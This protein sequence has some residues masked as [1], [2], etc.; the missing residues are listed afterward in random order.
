MTNPKVSYKPD[1]P[2]IRMQG[3]AKAVRPLC[4]MTQAL[5]C[6]Q[7][8]GKLGGE[9]RKATGGKVQLRFDDFC[10][11]EGLPMQ[12]MVGWA[13]DLHSSQRNFIREDCVPKTISG[14]TLSPYQL[15][16]ITSTPTSGGVHALGCGLGK[17]ITAVAA[18][19]G[20][21]DDGSA[22]ATRCWIVCPLNAVPAWE[23]VRADLEDVF[24]EVNIL[25]MDSAHKYQ[26][27]DRHAGGCIIYDEVHLLGSDTARR[28][29]A[30]HML[31]PAFQFGLCLTGTLLHGGIEKTMSI[32]DLAIPGAAMFSDRWAMGRHFNCLVRKQLG[33]RT[34][35]ELAKPVDRNREGFF[36]Y[37]DTV[38]QILNQDNAQVVN[39]IG[40]IQQTVHVIPMG[41]PYPDIHQQAADLAIQYYEDEGKY[42][43]ASW[44]RM[45]LLA[46]R[47]SVAGKISWLLEE[48]AG[49]EVQVVVFDYF[50]ENLNAIA[51]A[52]DKEKVSYVRVDGSVTG[53]DRAA[54]EEKFQRDH[55][56]V[57]LGQTHAASVS[58]NLQ[59]AF[60][61]VMFSPSQSAADYDQ[62]LHRTARRGQTSACH[63]FNLVSNK[64]Q[65]AVVKLVQQGR[66]F[67]AS[68]SI[69]Q[70]L[71]AVVAEVV[72]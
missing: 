3:T 10:R 42:P 58:M 32:M 28:T 49:N 41:A 63:H 19:I 46:D 12:R 48:M 70:E 27:L 62:A 55:A 60:V 68:A 21:V 40:G 6:Y 38:C 20:C 8:T 34:V 31:R 33:A 4:A 13:K 16:T 35:T 53:K 72:E 17:T 51:D 15:N 23:R 64:L 1:L 11:E 2:D 18:C 65:E 37:L 61:S 50:T 66:D 39:D 29:Q 9:L 5:A 22:Y 24:E 26:S 7:R 69:W 59:N 44:V 54:C 57:F 30:C 67:D 25:S 36:K 47:D 14:L 52:L 43:H 45:Q 56:R 71:N